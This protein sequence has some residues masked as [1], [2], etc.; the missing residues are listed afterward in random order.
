MERVHEL[1]VGR[2]RVP[3]VEQLFGRYVVLA[4]AEQPHIQDLPL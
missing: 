4:C 3:L 2:C 1:D